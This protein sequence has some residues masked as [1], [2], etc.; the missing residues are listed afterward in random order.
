MCVLCVDD[1]TKMEEPNLLTT[2]EDLEDRLLRLEY[3]LSQDVNANAKDASPQQAPPKDLKAPAKL[4]NL[5][6]RF[7]TLVSRQSMYSDILRL[8]EFNIL[9][10]SV[11]LMQSQI[12]PI[13]SFLKE[14]T[15]QT[16]PSC[17]LQR[18]WL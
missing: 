4:A 17:Q 9:L 7:S 1:M 14:T 6:N 5:E 12:I 11:M 16:N 15:L 3:L 10:A 13:L 8:S 2:I 18:S